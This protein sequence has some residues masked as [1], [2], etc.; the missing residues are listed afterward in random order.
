MSSVRVAWI[1]DIPVGAATCVVW[2][3]SA[4]LSAQMIVAEMAVRR[5]GR[6]CGYRGEQEKSKAGYVHDERK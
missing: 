4:L 2:C 1:T 3:Q 5:K 6:Y